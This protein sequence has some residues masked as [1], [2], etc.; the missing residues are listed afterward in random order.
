[1]L[2]PNEKR[3]REVGAAL[4]E[5]RL[6]WAFISADP[7]FHSVKTILEKMGFRE[8]LLY[9][10]GVSLVSYLLTTRGEEHWALAAEFSSRPYSQSLR[11]FV[12]ESPSLARL[13]E[14]RLRRLELYL[15]RAVPLLEPEIE[16]ESI[17]LSRILASLSTAMEATPDSKTSAFA[18]KMA[19]YTAVAGGRRFSGGDKVPIPVDYRVSLTTL[20]SGMLE[21]WTCQ[22]DIRRLAQ[23]IRSSLRTTIVRLWEAASKAA[24]KPPVLLDSVAWVSGLCIDENIERPAIIGECIARKV[25][26]DSYL[27]RLSVLWGYLDRCNYSRP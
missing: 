25:G 2:Y 10:V 20:T 9:I 24:E 8:G 1:M 4:G 5:P 11:K 21:G 27:D 6:V 17:D 12:R 3:A 7:Q 15:S 26:V 19:L 23:I 22:Q 13:R 16:K 14:Q 18:A